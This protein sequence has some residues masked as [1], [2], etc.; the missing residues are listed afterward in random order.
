MAVM[1][2]VRLERRLMG[3][4]ILAVLEI[5]RA[6]ETSIADYKSIL[7]AECQALQ[8]TGKGERMPSSFRQLF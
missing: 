4:T 5:A 6:C 7:R 8:L 2:P 1:D 3:S